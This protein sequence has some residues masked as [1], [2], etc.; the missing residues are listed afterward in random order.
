[1]EVQVGGFVRIRQD[2]RERMM[3]TGWQVDLASRHL[4]LDS[5]PLPPG[6][7]PQHP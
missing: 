2:A 1:M 3:G 6:I 4:T 5:Q 7:K